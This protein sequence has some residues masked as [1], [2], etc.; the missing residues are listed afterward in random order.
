MLLDLWGCW[1]LLKAFLV[2]TWHTLERA[3]T[4]SKKFLFNQQIIIEFEIK[5][6]RRWNLMNYLTA[7]SNDCWQLRKWS[8][9]FLSYI[10]YAFQ[11]IKWS[12]C[13]V[14]FEYQ[15]EDFSLPFLFH[16]NLNNFGF[17]IL[18]FDKLVL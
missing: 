7:K 1:R 8:K 5:I 3:Y 13:M 4:L 6:W 16:R 9:E 14:K 2:M 17:N 12:I 15:Q 11:I 10:H 18:F